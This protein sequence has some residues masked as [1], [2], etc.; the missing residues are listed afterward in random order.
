MSFVIDT[1]SSLKD[2]RKKFDKLTKKAFPFVKFRRTLAPSEDSNILFERSLNHKDNKEYIEVILPFITKELQSTIKITASLKNNALLFQVREP[3]R[4]T[5][6]PIRYSGNTNILRQQNLSN[7]EILQQSVYT[8]PMWID[9]NIGMSLIYDNPELASE[10][11]SDGLD[12]VILNNY[13]EL[14]YLIEDV[15]IDKKTLYGTIKINCPASNNYLVAGID[16]DSKNPYIT[17]INGQ[18]TGVDQAFDMLIPE[19]VKGKNYLR[20]GEWF[21]VPQKPLS[22]SILENVQDQEIEYAQPSAWQSEKDANIFLSR[23]IQNISVLYSEY[24]QEVNISERY[25]AVEEIRYIDRLE[26]NDGGALWVRGH[27]YSN[28]HKTIYLEDWHRVYH[29]AEMINLDQMWD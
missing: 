12:C 18:P 4:F 15:E 14:S 2:I 28:N 19:P 9:R 10:I 25:H 26:N 11:I 22:K 27:V 8:T 16:H 17:Q 13:E 20:Q 7:L 23:K 1:K 29:N 5:H 3:S 21:F 24:V 6:I